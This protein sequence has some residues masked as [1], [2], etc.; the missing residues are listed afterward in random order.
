MALEGRRKELE[1]EPFGQ[2]DAMPS[3]GRPRPPLE[4]VVRSAITVVVR[5]PNT[6]E[7]SLKKFPLPTLEVF[8]Q[9]RVLEDYRFHWPA[10]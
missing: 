9:R 5:V 4:L 2:R 8:S 7:W 6:F 1:M 3:L 10:Q